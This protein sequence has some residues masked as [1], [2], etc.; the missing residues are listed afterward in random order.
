MFNTMQ[1]IFC[2]TSLLTYFCWTVE[3]LLWEEKIDFVRHFSNMAAPAS[4]LVVLDLFF[5]RSQPYNLSKKPYYR[6]FC[7]SNLPTV[8][9]KPV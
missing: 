8:F 1:E 4:P 2:P 5:I 3:E 7:N 6:V 9:A